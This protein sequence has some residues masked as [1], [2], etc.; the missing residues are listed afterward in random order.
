MCLAQVKFP[1][2]TEE[3]GATTFT[4]VARIERIP[5]GLLITDLLGRVTRLQAEIRSIDFIESVVSLESRAGSE[6]ARAGRR[7][8]EHRSNTP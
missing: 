1:G 2:H 6:Q 8:P 5:G 4:D 7:K 3:D